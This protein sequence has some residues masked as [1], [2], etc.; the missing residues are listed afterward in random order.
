M[1]FPTDVTTMISCNNCMQPLT[2]NTSE[3][4][5]PLL[6]FL[7]PQ[8]IE[9]DHTFSIFRFVPSPLRKSLSNIYAQKVAF[10]IKGDSI[11]CT[12]E[13]FSASRI[14]LDSS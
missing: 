3:R 5:K 1:A 2:K 8:I 7:V 14:L 13:D 12:F 11:C 4:N 9:E 10:R 6:D